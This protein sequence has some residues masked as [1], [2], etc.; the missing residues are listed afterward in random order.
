M[1]KKKTLSERKREAIVNTAIDEFRERG[2]QQTSMDRIAEKA[3]VSK[4]TVYNHFSSKEELFI[5]ITQA[6]LRKTLDAT[7]YP[8]Q[9]DRPL[10]NQLREIA[11]REVEL[12]MT[13]SYISMARMVLGEYM[14]SPELAKQAMA[15]LEEQEGGLK[16]WLKL[17]V[18][19]QRLR[20]DDVNLMGSQFLNL[21][22]GGLFWP[23]IV[24]YAP[25]PDKEMSEKIVESTLA[26]FLA[27][28]ENKADGT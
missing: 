14:M 22:K 28:Y 21:L 2:F 18:Q 13:E 9:A 16:R 10:L 3:N 25:A 11:N 15:K 12:F 17:A 1:E 4:R 5:E 6:F 7:E 19:D 27:Y 20:S 26:V 23:Q 8:Y 24:G